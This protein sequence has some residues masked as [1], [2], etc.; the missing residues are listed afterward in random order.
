M[1]APTGTSAHPS[2]R[3]P[4]LAAAPTGFSHAAVYTSDIDRFRRF[5]EGVVGLHLGALLKMDGPPYHRHAIFP[6]G[7]V[8]TLHVFEMPG[9]DPQADGIGTEIGS[10]GRIDHFGFELP[11]LSDLEALG[12]RVAAAGASDGQIRPLGPS[13][14]LHFRDPD[15]LSVEVNCRRPIPAGEQ[16]PETLLEIGDPAWAAS[17]GVHA[18]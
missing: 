4:R 13:W 7:D 8:A 18:A 2:V 11:G 5:Y 14:S 15:G 9:Y 6:L 1:T 17:I 3:P 10:R 12:E 16:R